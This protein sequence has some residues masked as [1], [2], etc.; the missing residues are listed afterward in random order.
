MSVL[1]VLT[2]LPALLSLF[3]RWILGKRK[4]SE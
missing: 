4:V 1:L 2:L 3:D